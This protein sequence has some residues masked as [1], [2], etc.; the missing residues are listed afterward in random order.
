MNTFFERPVTSAL[1]RDISMDDAESKV[2]LDV[3]TV[4]SHG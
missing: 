2:E 4:R 3:S 1:E